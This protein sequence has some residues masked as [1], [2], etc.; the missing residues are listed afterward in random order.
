MTALPA[1]RPAEGPRLDV[2]MAGRSATH[3]IGKAEFVIGSGIGCDLRI[4]GQQVPATFCRIDRRDDAS[5]HLVSLSPT[6]PILVNGQPISPETPT[7]LHAN[8]RLTIGPADVTVRWHEP[9]ARPKLFAPEVE[10]RH[11][12]PTFVPAAPV[13][14][15]PV[16]EPPLRRPLDDLHAQLIARSRE[17]DERAKDL[18]E[19]RVLWYRRR[20]ELEAELQKL[21]D[22]APAIDWRQKDAEF[23]T[24]ELD[25]ARARDELSTLRQSLYDQYRERRDQLGE[26]QDAVRAQAAAVAER[27]AV[28]RDRETA[29]QSRWDDAERLR[30]EAA[31]YEP[32]LTKLRDRETQIEAAL[33]EIERQR[34]AA[35]K[36]RDDLAADRESFDRERAMF[37]ARWQDGDR[38]LAARDVELRRREDE[39]HRGFESLAAERAKAVHA[40]A[41]FDGR[42]ADLDRRQQTLDR[43]AA[44]IDARH[45]QL[46]RDAGELEEHLRLVDAERQRAADESDRLA[47]QAAD[48]GR[49]EAELAERSTAVEAQQAALLVF[50]STLDRR[51]REWQAGE[52]ESAERRSLLAESQVEIDNRLR[53]AEALRLELNRVRD[54]T[55]ALART[56]NDRQARLDADG[57][58]LRQAQA[59]LAAERESLTTKERNL[60]ARSTEL[61]EQTAILKARVVQVHELQ[62][63]LE[64]D[65]G[66]VRE[67]EGRL[68][69]SES[70][71]LALQEQLRKRAEELQQRAK[72]LDAQA[73][74]HASERVAVEQRI[75]ELARDR[76]RFAANVAERETAIATAKDEVDRLRTEIAGREEALARQVARLRDV[77]QAV[78]AERKS[79][80]A[81]KQEWERTRAAALADD[82]RRIHL[83][84]Q[85]ERDG[86]DRTAELRRQLPE[87]DRRATA[88]LGQIAAARDMLRGQL[89]ELHAF[90]GQGRDDFEVAR[91]ALA[92]EAAALRDRETQFEA[93][94]G[95][96]RVAVAG[97]RQHLAEWQ[98]QVHELRQTLLAGESNF[99]DRQAEIDAIRRQADDRARDLARRESELHDARRLV[100]E[101]RGEIEKH[102]N[103][104]REWYRK[105]LRE[106]ASGSIHIHATADEPGDLPPGDK[107]LGELLKQRGLV[108]PRT[109]QTL[110]A[111]ATRQRRTLR[112]V[113]LASGTLTLYQLALIEAGNLDALVVGRFRVI[114][115]IPSSNRETVLK[116]FDPER[117]GEPGHGTVVLRMLAESELHDA[118][119]PDEFRQ[120][121][122]TLAAASHPNLVNVLDVLELSGRPAAL[123]EWVGGLASGEWPALSAGLWL[124]LL[125]DTVAGLA[126]LHRT[127]LPH[128]RLTADAVMLTPVGLVKVANGGVPNWLDHRAEPT[129]DPFDHDLRILAELA[130]GWAAKLPTE[131]R[132]GRKAKP[133]PDPLQ[134]ML[135]RLAAGAAFPMADEVA[136]AEP[137]QDADHL[138]VDLHR[139]G[140]AYPCPPAEWGAL[141]DFVAETLKGTMPVALRKAG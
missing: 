31:G 64:M 136:R 59:D 140:A 119:R 129:G 91:Q 63:R 108:E 11:L 54:D 25:L 41:S 111:E 90:A 99:G 110:W 33:A 116:V 80:F 55:E 135:R 4:P 68:G 48:L 137:Y 85:Q 73:L 120:R 121:F 19:D 107:H 29:A 89:A 112:Q 95:E 114:D 23:A 132:K 3:A 46:A 78:A 5:L 18:D 56:L 117:A 125:T 32:R 20:Q 14:V 34:L 118:V 66:A 76:E 62:E 106:L 8:D 72:A 60:D 82:E 58:V 16:A 77:G 40:V 50:R 13:G 124:K 71:R 9:V 109:L 103:D 2:R 52:R 101:R 75:A 22:A 127:G 130:T 83:V 84:A 115:R 44:E 17:L 7:P 74:A 92:T 100:D 69:E 98:A 141:L 79:L 27:E 38:Q 94:R 122:A 123:Q 128:G 6:F 30:A 28:V 93:A 133:L 81:A 70:A 21:R 47:R 67:R 26:L 35:A 134:A 36:L 57:T 15:Q 37:D 24:K 96:H 104:L 86:A 102:L 53:D 126:T 105:K 87:L 138:L 1:D 65:R 43:R 61:A 39:L 45:E 113:L 88:A 12:H 51:D 97:F 42:F 139:L 131:G 49:R 10:P